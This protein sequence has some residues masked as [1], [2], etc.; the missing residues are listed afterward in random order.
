[1][2]NSANYCKYSHFHVDKSAVDDALVRFGMDS[3]RMMNIDFDLAAAQNDVQVSPPGVDL[4]SIARMH[5]DLF[6]QAKDK[7]RDWRRELDDDARANE[8]TFGKKP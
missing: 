2:P 4:P 7:P 6:V 5:Y 3:T 1:M 8:E